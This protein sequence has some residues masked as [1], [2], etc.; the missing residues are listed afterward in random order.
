MR[1]KDG[2]K[3]RQSREEG[4]HELALYGKVAESSDVNNKSIRSNGLI[5]TE[6]ADT[7]WCGS[8]WG[9]TNL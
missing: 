5:F 3:E 1:H 7:L 4:E 2:R 6:P 8:K 9:C